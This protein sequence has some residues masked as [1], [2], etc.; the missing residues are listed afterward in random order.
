MLFRGPSEEYEVKKSEIQMKKS[1][2]NR[3]VRGDNWGE[4]ITEKYREEERRKA[5]QEL[6]EEEKIKRESLEKLG[7]GE[8]L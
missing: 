3:I 1:P 2:F 8:Y 5:I 7:E 4:D 6:D